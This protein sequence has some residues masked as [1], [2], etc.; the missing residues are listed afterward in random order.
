[1]SMEWQSIDSAPK[2]GRSIVLWC[3]NSQTLLLDM[4][5]HKG[6]WYE[7]RAGQCD[8]IDAEDYF[9]IHPEDIPSHWF[10]II[11]PQ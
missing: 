4:I 3:E 5:W 9:P 1:M 7:W 8:E 10:E 2:D 6:N 11:P